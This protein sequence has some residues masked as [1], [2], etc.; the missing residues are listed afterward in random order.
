MVLALKRSQDRSPP[1][2]QQRRLHERRPLLQ[3]PAAED[4][5]DPPRTT[6]A[7][8]DVWRGLDRGEFPF[9]HYIADEY[10]VHEDADQFRSGLDLLLTALRS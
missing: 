4:S 3:Q 6:A 10:A 7:Q 2:R 5:A 8:A 9:V 1:R